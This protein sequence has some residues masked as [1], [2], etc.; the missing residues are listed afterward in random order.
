MPHESKNKKLALAEAEKLR[1]QMGFPKDTETQSVAPGEVMAQLIHAAVDVDK[2]GARYLLERM[3]NVEGNEDPARQPEYDMLFKKLAALANSEMSRVPSLKAQLV[4]R[5]MQNRDRSAYREYFGSRKETHK[6]TIESFL[7]AQHSAYQLSLSAKA[8]QETKQMATKIWALLRRARVFEFEPIDVLPIMDAIL[9]GNG[10]SGLPGELTLREVITKVATEDDQEIVKACYRS[11]KGF[12]DKEVWPEL[13]FEVCYIGYGTG[14]SIPDSMLWTGGYHEMLSDSG[15]LD[16]TGHL[17]THDGYVYEFAKN[18]EL[19]EFEVNAVAF[20]AIRTPSSGWSQ[21]FSAFNW[22]LFELM[23]QMNENQRIIVDGLGHKMMYK[24]LLKQSGLKVKK[25][26]PPP[27]YTVWVEPKLIY[28]KS[29]HNPNPKEI[30]WSHRW[31]SEA[32]WAHRISR[33]SL[34]ID[35]KVEARMLKETKSG[36]KYHIWKTGEVPSW[37]NKLLSVRGQRPKQVGE[38]IA[39]L[40]YRVTASIKGPPDREYIPASRKVKRKKNSRQTTNQRRI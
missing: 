11:M 38:W 17:L 10:Y 8:P 7:G 35:P 22:M 20:S 18:I 23:R 19:T 31:D 26:I 3:S 27:Y 2:A 4:M 14:I 21:P 39:I 15:E 40:R 25:M 37:V 24:K 12:L 36:A 1:R 32:H 13:P 9:D 33:G 16:V 6:F 34:P 28:N 30:D 29:K 5:D